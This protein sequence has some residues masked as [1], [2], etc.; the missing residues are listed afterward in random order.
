ML[1]LV[2]VPLKLVFALS[3]TLHYPIHHPPQ[4]FAEASDVQTQKFRRKATVLTGKESDAELVDKAKKLSLGEW[5]MGVA[6]SPF[7]L[8]AEAVQHGAAILF[9]CIG[10]LIH[11]PRFAAGGLVWLAL[12]FY[13]YAFGGA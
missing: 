6:A 5:C 3:N 11:S 13:T 4:G 12:S 10:L 1:A 9:Y 7:T 8:F 2:I